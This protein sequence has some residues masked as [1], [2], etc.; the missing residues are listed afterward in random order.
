VSA[1]LHL[2]TPVSKATTLVAGGGL[3]WAYQYQDGLAVVDP[4][5]ARV[6]RRIPLPPATPLAKNHAYF[7]HGV[8]WMAQPGQLWRVGFPSAEP[9]RVAL[10]PG[11]DPDV[12]AAT[13]HWLWLASGRRLVRIDPATGAVSTTVDL[14]VP[15][16]VTGLLGTQT[17]LFAVGLN[18][19]AVWFLDPDSGALSSTVPVS[20]GELVRMVYAENGVVW[21]T[22]NCGGVLRV[23]TTAGVERVKVSGLP[24][25]SGGVTALGSLWVADQEG[26]GVVRVDLHTGAVSARIPVPVP[27]PEDAE[28]AVMAGQRSLWVV[29]TNSVYGVLRMDPATNRL[30]RIAAG[31]AA[32]TGAVPPVGVSA[33]VGGS[34]GA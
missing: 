27:D 32:P 12:V 10:P 4:V 15:T 34:P 26:A 29:D 23:S 16:G 5:A 9:T 30:W 18:Q 14:T 24:V 3:I 17:G 19:A 31:G 22:G 6:V 28:F 1:Q 33:V 2:G 20:G 8:L 7:A 11:V 25:D 21:A 13:G